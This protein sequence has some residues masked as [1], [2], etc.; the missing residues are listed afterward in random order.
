MHVDT[1]M[2]HTNE[3]NNEII[4]SYASAYYLAQKPNF[5]SALRNTADQNRAI[6]LPTAHGGSSLILGATLELR[7]SY[8]S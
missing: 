1:I 3:T 8:V 5:S 4:R 2:T 7:K 6:I